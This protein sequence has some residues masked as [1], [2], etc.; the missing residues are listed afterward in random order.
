M[1]H[2]RY[3]EYGGED[4]V[5]DA[6]ITLLRSRGVE[7]LSLDAYNHT[8]S[9]LRLKGSL[10]L[11]MH[12]HWS[13]ES[14]DGVR[15]ICREFQPDVAH[16]HNFWMRL[17]PA[18]HA[19]CHDEGVPTIQTLHNFRL[20]CVNAQFQRSGHTCHDCLARVPWRGVVHRCYR[21]SFMAS[22]AV[23]RMI[24]TSRLHNIW[25]E[26]VNAF[27][28]LSEYARRLFITGGIPAERIRIKPNFVEDRSSVRMPPSRSAQFLFVGRLSPEKGVA[29]LLCA[30]AECRVGLEARLIILGDG[31]ERNR[32]LNQ[33][34]RLGIS[35]RVTFMGYQQPVE[36]MSLLG[37]A[38]AVIIPS[39]YQE[40]FPR[41]LAEA[42]SAGRPVIAS[43]I[44]GL[45]E[46]VTPDIG[47]LAP[48]SNAAALAELIETLYQ[49]PSLADRL[50]AAARARYLL[51]Y[52]PQRNF[53]TLMQIY[54][55]A[56]T[57][58]EPKPVARMSAGGVG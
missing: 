11:A 14:Y 28:V 31:P 45:D 20:F 43:Q 51:A 1:L 33:A 7:V 29:T 23:A 10:A 27:I 18:V 6:E 54:E 34:V 53:D 58:V 52:T 48:P 9:R 15:R 47:L 57:G 35:D 46:L 21:D 26:R 49:D 4:A 42:L 36:V 13:K 25:S 55:F 5:A 17:T 56:M 39:L 19:A 40:C 16:T 37:G 8:D 32:L 50:G 24:M 2:N 41:I 12:S 22:A 30:W 38:R 3:R 44:C